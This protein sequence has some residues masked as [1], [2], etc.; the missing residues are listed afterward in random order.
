MKVF[1]QLSLPT[2]ST[3]QQTNLNSPIS[4]KEVLTAIKTLQNGKAP[5]PD[6][7]CSE[8]YKEFCHLLADPLVV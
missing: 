3:E 4:R 1:S 2:I 7:F 6:Q 8:Y 5:G